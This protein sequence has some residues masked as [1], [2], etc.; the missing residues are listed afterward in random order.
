[1]YKNLSIY[2]Y[3]VVEDRNVI[4]NSVVSDP[5]SVKCVSQTRI[6]YKLSNSNVAVLSVDDAMI[7][8]Q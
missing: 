5:L 1:M 8:S 2:K 3:Y 7:D 6:C 4:K